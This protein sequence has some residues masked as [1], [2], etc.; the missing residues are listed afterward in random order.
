MKKSVDAEL[1][2]F[3]IAGELSLSGKTRP[4]KGTLPMAMLANKLRKRGLNVPAIS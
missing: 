4:V 3:L 1:S 2:N